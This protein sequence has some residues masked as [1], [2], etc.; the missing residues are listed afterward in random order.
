M[1]CDIEILEILNLLLN[2]HVTHLKDRRLSLGDYIHSLSDRTK[3]HL[4]N[5]AFED[6][7]TYQ[8][9]YH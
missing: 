9:F 3:S 4:D 8:L 2:D 1:I 6:L 5:E 7:F